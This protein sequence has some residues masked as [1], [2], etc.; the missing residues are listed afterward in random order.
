[1]PITPNHII[2]VADPEAEPP[3]VPDSLPVAMAKTNQFMD[4]TAEV[5]EGLE[6]VLDPQIPGRLAA[7]EGAIAELPTKTYVDGLVGGLL[8]D[9][10]SHNASGNAFPASGGSGTAG[11]ILKG[12][13][14]YISVGGTLGGVS[15]AVGSSIRAL[16]DTPGQTAGNWDILS[17][18]LGY[19]PEN[20]ANRRTSFQATPDDTH[21][22]T[23]K[24]VKDSLD[25]KISHSLATAVNDFLVASGIGVF[26]KK[27]LAE[28]KTIL[29]VGAASGIA[30]L[31][32]STLVVENPANAQTTPGAGK[33]PMGDGTFGRLG[34]WEFFERNAD[35]QLTRTDSNTVTLAGIDGISKAIRVGDTIVDVSTSLTLDTDSA[36]E[37]IISGTTSVSK[38][39]ALNSYNGNGSDGNV[40]TA[41][42][43][44]H[45][46][47]CNAAA[48]WEFASY[49]RR[50]KLI[51]SPNAPT[52]GYLAASGDGLNARHVG[53]LICGA[54]R[55][56]DNDLCVAGRFNSQPRSY[57]LAGVTGD[58]AL[59]PNGTEVDLPNSECQFWAILAAGQTVAM[60]AWLYVQNN[61]TDLMIITAKWYSGATQEGFDNESMGSAAGYRNTALLGMTSFR[62]VAT[63]V[64]VLCKLRVQPQNVPAASPHVNPSASGLM[65]NT[66]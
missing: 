16:V 46:Y 12:D 63:T 44:H 66:W 37:F 10:G 58:T 27:T 9:R 38:S 48:C 45:L 65:V 60:R 52:S 20:S 4:D 28:V 31:N 23:E 25:T 14:W 53:W 64:A 62:A 13:L 35:V 30:S 41:H 18:G 55:T 40:Y 29:G 6:E 5:V 61:D 36:S 56:L 54:S 11:A 50:N 22:P 24:L 33:I 17:V 7:V 8:D 47:I 1:M 34:L 59:T 51:L 49:D 26:V 43:L 42:G 15:V 39:T 57:S 3:V 2:I 21:Y 19:V 32:A